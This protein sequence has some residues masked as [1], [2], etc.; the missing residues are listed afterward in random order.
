MKIVNIAGLAAAFMAAAVVASL[1]ARADGP[2][3]HIV[4]VISDYDNLRMYFKPKMLIVN[5]GDTVTWI[6][7]AEE[8]HNVL[9]YPDGFPKGAMPMKS[10]YLAKK[11]EKW[12]FTFKAKGSYQYHCIPHLPMGMH[13]TVIVSQLSKDDDFHV[14]TAKELA[15]YRDHLREYFDSDDFQYKSRDERKSKQ[16]ASAAK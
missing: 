12:S 7:E 11:D 10:P 5:P 3:K 16:K 1:P 2:K 6:N 4:R 9:S 14:P 8:D 15:S 13:G